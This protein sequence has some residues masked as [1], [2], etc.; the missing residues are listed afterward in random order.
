VNTKL[1]PKLDPSAVVAIVDSREQNPLDL[2]PLHTV[3][4]SLQTGDYALQGC[5]EIRIERKRKDFLPTL[6]PSSKNSL[7]RHW[8]RKRDQNALKK[9]E[10]FFESDE[11]VTSFDNLP[12]EDSSASWRMYRL[13]CIAKFVGS[14]RLGC[15]FTEVSAF[16]STEFGTS[17]RTTRRD[18]GV[19]GT[20]GLIRTQRDGASVRL[21]VERNWI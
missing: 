3:S 21:F 17:V 19:L 5:D 11:S 18:V 1:P 9:M 16:A 20:V 10:D 7:R 2:T 12:S 14:K 8:F 15:R 4:G 13:L 6:K